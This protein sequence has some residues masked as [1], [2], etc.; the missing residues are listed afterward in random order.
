MEQTNE[1]LQLK[2]VAL[3]E[4]FRNKVSTLM[5]DYEDKIADLRIELTEISQERDT[6]RQQVTEREN[7]I[8]ELENRVQEED[9]AD[10]S[11]DAN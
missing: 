11:D 5:D 9:P 6:L 10:S 3:K 2:I 1:R 7:R 8:S 4:G